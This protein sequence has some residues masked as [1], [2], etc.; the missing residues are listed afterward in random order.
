MPQNTFE[1]QSDSEQGDDDQQVHHRHDGIK[2]FGRKDGVPNKYPQWKRVRSLAS[3]RL[4]EIRSQSEVR[5]HKPSI[6]SN[7]HSDSAN[8][9]RRNTIST[10]TAS[11]LK[12]HSFEQAAEQI[13]KTEE[14]KEEKQKKR[15]HSRS[16]SESSI[17]SQKLLSSP[18]IKDF[19]VRSEVEQYVK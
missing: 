19:L 16:S 10:P 2:L 7:D 15:R 6:R 1:V 11:E 14:I 8:N 4:E 3:C 12:V 17:K 5:G 13:I 9:T 18:F